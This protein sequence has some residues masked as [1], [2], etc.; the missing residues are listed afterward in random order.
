MMRSRTIREG[1]VGLLILLG[2]MTF[3]GLIL[4]LRGLNLGNSAYTIQ[5][6]FSDIAGMQPGAPVRYRGVSIGRV[7]RIQPGSNYARV[8]VEVNSTKLVIPRNVIVEANQVGLIGETSIDIV[9]QSDLSPSALEMNPRSSDCDEGVILCEGF[10]LEGTVGV[11]YDTLIRTTAKLAERFDNPELV[12][13]IKTLVTNTSDAAAGVAMLTN[14]VTELTSSLQGD[15]GTL[16]SSIQEDLGV[17]STAATA[18]ANSVTAAATELEL[19]SA[20]LTGLLANNRATLSSTLAN[21]DAISN[22]VQ[23]MATVLTPVIESG[24]LV[25]NLETLST[26]AAAASANL[27]AISG[28]F[29]SSDALVQLQQT[30]DSAHETFENA[31]KITADLDELTGDPEFRQNVRLLVDGLSDLVSTTE[32]LEQQTEIAQV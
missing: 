1:S 26:N 12:Q 27:R 14:E 9:P 4:W 29:S 20:E 25:G 10:V 7:L 31:R 18:T 17:L 28:A 32:Q 16:T 21:I 5:V 24:E 30:L 2:I 23:R 19:T 3:G 6:D 13:E 15:I 8:T 11:S 22:D